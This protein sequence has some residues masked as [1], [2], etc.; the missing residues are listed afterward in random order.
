M[1]RSFKLVTILFAAAIFSTACNLNLLPGVLSEAESEDI[2]PTVAL[3]LVLNSLNSSAQ[4]TATIPFQALDSN[5][6]NF[7]CDSTFFTSTTTT[8]A[9]NTPLD[10][11]FYIHD[12]KLV[13]WNGST[14]SAPLTDSGS[15]QASGAALLDFENAAGN[16]IT[17]N[18]TF[19]G[20][21]DTNTSVSIAAP[22]GNWQG[23]EFTVGLPYALQRQQAS[24]ATTSAPFNVTDMYWSWTAGYKFI[25]MEWNDAGGNRIRYHLGSTGC[26]AGSDG[27]Q[28]SCTNEY[29]ASIRAT[30][31]DGFDP[32]TDTIVFNIPG[33]LN[34]FPGNNA[35][36][37]C[38]VL[39][40][41]TNCETLVTNS[42]LNSSSGASTG[43]GSMF[44]I[45]KG[46]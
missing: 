35:D 29:R 42:G 32:T 9:T 30:S 27:A 20:T 13:D 2:P 28:E 7:S 6:S 22:A 19:T 33:L 40:D 44:T 3:G 16:C 10:L 8:S 17:G 4:E 34:G 45:Q 14:S 46:R 36:T 39:Q 21:T 5:G 31:S 15:F 23:V 1:A 18:A 43:S 11:R 41:G 38:M 24:A 25:L 26:T 37:Q 12:F